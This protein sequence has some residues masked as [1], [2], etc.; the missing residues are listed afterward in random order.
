[1]YLMI[2]TY[3][4][5]LDKVDEARADHLAFLAGLE[6]RGLVVSAGRQEPAVGGVVILGVPT[7]AEAVELMAQD[8]YVQR[9]L[10]D[11]KAIGWQPSRGVL[12]DWKPAADR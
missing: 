7:E 10:A 5:P 11:Y 6:E 2:S 3:Q 8:P 1:M 9:G 12:A 4:A